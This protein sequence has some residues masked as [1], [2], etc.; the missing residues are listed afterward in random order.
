MHIKTLMIPRFKTLMLRNR[1]KN[2]TIIKI[3]KVMLPKVKL[4]Y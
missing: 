1:Y 4:T 3:G 2:G